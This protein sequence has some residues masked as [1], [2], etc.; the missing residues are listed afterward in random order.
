MN[1]TLKW[2]CDEC[3]MIHDREEFAVECCAPDV[4]DVYVC[5]ECDEEYDDKT[6]AEEC[7][8]EDEDDQLRPRP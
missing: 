1:P 8:M 5:E 4:S 6:E 7:C 2:R 3:G